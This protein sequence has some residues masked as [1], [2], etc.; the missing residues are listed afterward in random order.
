MEGVFLGQIGLFPYGFEPTG[1]ALCDG[2]CLA[3]KDHSKLHSLIGTKHGG[4]GT[5]CFAL[6]NLMGREPIPNTNYYIALKGE[7]PTE[8]E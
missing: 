8:E 3:I 7:S 6:P 5:I 2:R 1:W 4:D